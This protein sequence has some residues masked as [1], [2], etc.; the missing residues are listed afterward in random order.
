MR[1]VDAAKALLI[2]S[3][4]RLETARRELNEGSIAYSIRSSQESV[5]LALK[6]ALRLLGIEYPKKHDVSPALMK[7]RDRF[8]AWFPVDEMADVSRKLMEKREPAMYG[9]ELSTT[10]ADLLFSRPEA[11]EALRYAEQAHEAVKK[12]FAEYSA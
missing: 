10:P 1:N 6:A 5:E 2:Q 11:E 9:D 3:A 7:F 4:R 8:P 12:L